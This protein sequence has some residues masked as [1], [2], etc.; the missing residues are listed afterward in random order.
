MKTALTINALVALSSPAAAYLS[1][2]YTNVS[3]PYY[4]QSPP[5]Y[6]SRESFCKSTVMLSL[7][8][9]QPPAMD[10]ATPSGLPHTLKLLVYSLK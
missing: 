10:Q 1:G 8:A 3:D 5:V 9:S 6:P 2:S 4:G 7:T